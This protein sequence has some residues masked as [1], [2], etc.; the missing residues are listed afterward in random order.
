MAEPSQQQSVLTAVIPVND[1]IDGLPSVPIVN[2]VPSKRDIDRLVDYT[3]GMGRYRGGFA[4][5]RA[6]AANPRASFQNENP[7][8]T[9]ALPPDDITD[10]VR[11]EHRI[12]SVVTADLTLDLAVDRAQA[13]ELNDLYERTVLATSLPANGVDWISWM[14]SINEFKCSGPTTARLDETMRERGNSR[15]TPSKFLYRCPKDAYSSPRRDLFVRHLTRC[16]GKL[17]RGTTFTPVLGLVALGYFPQ[18]K[19]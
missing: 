8:A 19:T 15:N 1:S 3:P 6:R 17:S 10:I 12:S 18:S 9:T 5:K 2:A 14:T 7:V 13:N 16:K 4:V 11:T